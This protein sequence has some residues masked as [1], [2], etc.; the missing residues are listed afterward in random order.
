M[1]IRPALYVVATPI[2]NLG[3]I[4]QRAIEILSSVS[5]IAAE[6]TRHSQKL[7][8]HLGINTNIISVHEHNERVKTDSLVE[9]ILGGESIALI[10]D[11]GTPLIS[12]PG[13]ILVKTAIESGVSV[14]PIPGVSALI[15]ALSASGLAS[16]R[17]LFEGFLPAKSSAKFKKL[18]AVKKEVSTVIFYE[19]PHRVLATLEAMEEVFGSERRVTMAREITKTFETIKTLPV[20][21]LLE[22]MAAD[23]NQQK[24]EFVLLVEGAGVLDNGIGIDIEKCMRLLIGALP[25]KKAASIA[26]EITGHPKKELYNL[27]L[28]IQ[29]KKKAETNT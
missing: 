22:F 6:D 11:A 3:D 7:L 18:E 24:G 19:S 15:A 23:V 20:S 16:D 27:G 12:D 13:Y 2:G 1:S 21:E 8:A 29:G 14:I 4:T 26:A 5:L 17:F 25:I 9:S 10:S 28:Q